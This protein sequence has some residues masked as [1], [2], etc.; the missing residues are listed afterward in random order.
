MGVPLTYMTGDNMSAI[1]QLHPT[2]IPSRDHTIKLT[3]RPR[4][5]D[6]SYSIIHTRTI[7]LTSHAP[8]YDRALE[9]AKRDIDILLDGK[10]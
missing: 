2:T 1:K 8:R 5:N 4:I 3:H 10:T 7:E 9:A 6:W